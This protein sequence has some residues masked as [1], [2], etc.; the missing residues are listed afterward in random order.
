[1]R[2]FLNHATGCANRKLYAMR[3][4]IIAVKCLTGDISVQRLYAVNQTFFCQCRQS[5]VN[6]GRCLNA[7]HP[8]LV[9][10]S[11]GGKRLRL[12][13]QQTQHLLPMPA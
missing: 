7:I 9:K 11:I 10:N 5:P 3:M 2:Q 1:M 8:Q 6:R 4:T 13:A 12:T